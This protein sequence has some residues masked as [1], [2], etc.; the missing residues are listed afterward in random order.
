MY[1]NDCSS[2]TQSD[3]DGDQDQ[4]KVVDEIKLGTG[5]VHFLAYLLP[6]P[7]HYMMLLHRRPRALDEHT[8][9]SGVSTVLSLHVYLIKSFLRSI[10][11]N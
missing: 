2:S 10:G 6:K 4:Q 5:E 9:A 3:V 7:L 8:G 11:D 1:N